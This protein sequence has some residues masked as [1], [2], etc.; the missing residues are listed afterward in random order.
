MRIIKI[1]EIRVKFTTRKIYF[2]EYR[3]YREDWWCVGTL[4]LFFFLVFVGWIN[5]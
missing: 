2:F 1:R 4:D 3:S 5:K